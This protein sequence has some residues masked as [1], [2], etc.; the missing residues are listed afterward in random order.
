MTVA[1]SSSPYRVERIASA[2]RVVCGCGW[3]SKFA[4]SESGALGELER[5][6]RKQHQRRS[7]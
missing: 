6:R 4:P 2:Y 7:S 3:K 5:H 1:E